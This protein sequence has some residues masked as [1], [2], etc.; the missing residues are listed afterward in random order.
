MEEWID[1]KPIANQA[2]VSA[3]CSL[4][5][6]SRTRKIVVEVLPEQMQAT[7]L[8]VKKSGQITYSELRCAKYGREIG[9]AKERALI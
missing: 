1:K 8:S 6:D 9:R 7:P 2:A 5:G 4:C 3:P